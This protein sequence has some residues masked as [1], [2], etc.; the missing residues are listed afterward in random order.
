MTDSISP[1][2][3]RVLARMLVMLGDNK[4]RL[5]MRYAEWCN[6]APTLEAAIAAAA[7]T[8]DEL[9]HSRSIYAVVKE[10]EHQ[11]EVF[12]EDETTR[13]TFLNMKCL[14]REFETWPDFVA[15]NAIADQMMAVF[16]E[17]A[18]DSAFE[19]LANRAQKIVQEEHY[20]FLY[21]Q[22]WSGQLAKT[23]ATREALI[24]SA[25]R[26][27][28]EVL[29]WFG[30]QNDP[31]LKLLHDERVLDG[32]GATLR[33][34]FEERVANLIGQFGFDAPTSEEIS[35]DSWDVDTRRFAEA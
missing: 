8:Q 30:P 35:W 11:P 34:R 2:A 16:F 9:G 33:S 14:E 6:S 5:G 29:A 7:M 21:A 18:K 19:R 32:D 17:A 31:Q 25:S 27:W 3:D 26:M 10:C 22:S 28:P 23:D 12:D 15:A 13:D 24:K 4:Y 20:H 1:E